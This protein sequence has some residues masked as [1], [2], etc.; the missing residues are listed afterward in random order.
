MSGLC[1]RACGGRWIGVFRGLGFGDIL[2][3]L[4]EI[5]VAEEGAVGGGN[6]ASG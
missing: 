6:P 1:L 5:V 3:V 4:L 2:G